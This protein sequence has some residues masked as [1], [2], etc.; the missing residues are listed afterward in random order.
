MQARFTAA[1]RKQLEEMINDHM[2]LKAI[3]EALGRHPTSVSREV[4]R[5]RAKCTMVTRSKFTRNRCAMRN[6]CKVRG[7]CGST[8]RKKKC[9]SCTYIACIDRCKHYVEQSCATT[10]KW[11]YTC[12]RCKQFATCPEQRYIYDVRR[13]QKIAASRASLSRRGIDL[14]A[15]E[16]ERL[17]SLITPLV[18][19]GQSLFH[20]WTN[21][22]Y[23]IGLSLATLYT[24]MNL[25]LFSARRIHLPRA[26]HFRPRRKKKDSANKR[27]DIKERAYSDYLSYLTGGHR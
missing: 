7:I 10:D 25:G 11:P 19:K 18:Y 1:E 3:A 6:S 20:I 16:P 2:P 8:K 9:I 22:R 23:E 13:A 26:V 4:R 24:Y 14:D 15:G 17:D 27:A 5:N 21:H 12:N